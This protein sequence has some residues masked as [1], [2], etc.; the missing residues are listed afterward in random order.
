MLGNLR[1]GFCSD[2]EAYFE[3][4]DIWQKTTVFRRLDAVEIR[5]DTRD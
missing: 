1:S 3:V 5:L 4:F 2:I